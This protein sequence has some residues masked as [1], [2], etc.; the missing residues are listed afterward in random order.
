MQYFAVKKS[1]AVSG[2]S[3]RSSQKDKRKT[4]QYDVL[5]I[6]ATNVMTITAAMIVM[7]IVKIANTCQHKQSECGPQEAFHPI[8]GVNMVE[9]SLR[10]MHRNAML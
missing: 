3:I 4:L 9:L 8:R 2:R 6:T 1:S 7:N 5:R 10:E